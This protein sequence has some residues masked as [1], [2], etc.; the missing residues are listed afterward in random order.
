M[1]SYE[2]ERKALIEK[3][4]TVEKIVIHLSDE[5]KVKLLEVELLVLDS[6]RSRELASQDF[7]SYS[8]T[9]LELRRWLFKLLNK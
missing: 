4:A 9:C 6:E 7:I 1:Y 3:I 2:R 5:R 8:Q